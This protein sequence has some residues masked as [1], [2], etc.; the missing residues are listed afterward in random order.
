[1]SIT[2]L[3]SVRVECARVCKGRYCPNL[4]VF[5]VRRVAQTPIGEMTW[6][7]P[8]VGFTC[9]AFELVVPRVYHLTGSIVTA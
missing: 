8:H 6:G 5:D 1:M 4:E 2:L 7:G 3:K 9:G